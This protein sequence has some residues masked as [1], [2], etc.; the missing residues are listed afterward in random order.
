L[1]DGKDGYDFLDGKSPPS[2][3]GVKPLPFPST[4]SDKRFLG[5]VLEAGI[6]TFMPGDFRV[7]FPRSSYAGEPLSA[8]N[9]G[10]SLFLS[11]V[12]FFFLIARWGGGRVWRL[13]GVLRSWS[14][15]LVVVGVHRCV[16]DSVMFGG[17][18]G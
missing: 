6:S 5:G 9:V 10:L 16:V 7:V 15:F 11:V 18:S 17:C 8:R 13:G 4:L 1:R 12:E 3:S 2:D 14:G